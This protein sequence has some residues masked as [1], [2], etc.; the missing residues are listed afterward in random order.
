M[1]SRRAYAIANPGVEYVVLQIAGGELALQLPPGAYDLEWFSLESRE[2]TDGERLTVETEAA[3]VLAPV[4]SGS[5]VAHLK[6][7]S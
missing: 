7:A 5:S 6:R 3:T 1:E 2:W 4:G